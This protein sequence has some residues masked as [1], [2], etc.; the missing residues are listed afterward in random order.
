MIA[1]PSMPCAILA[2]FVAA[3]DPAP[4]PLMASRPADSASAPAPAPVPDA[5]PPPDAGCDE[6]SCERAMWRER[7]GW[8]DEC[9]NFDAGSGI[10]VYRLDADR[11]LVRVI[12]TLGA[13]QGM[14]RIYLWTGGRGRLLVFPV[15]DS[16]RPGKLEVTSDLSNFAD[17]EADKKELVV[18]RRYR[19][20]GDCGSWVR[21]G[22]SGATVVVREMRQ[23]QACVGGTTDPKRWPIWHPRR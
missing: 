18:W 14:A 21:Y 20:L 22:F 8:D 2:I 9:E 6:A 10:D 23:Q 13:Y 19:G 7:L 4:A 3:C 17:F 16:N 12:C 11:S 1:R 15:P 5:G